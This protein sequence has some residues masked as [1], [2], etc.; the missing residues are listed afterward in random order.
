MQDVWLAPAI[1]LPAPRIAESLAPLGGLVWLDG[2]L[3]YGREGRFSFLGAEPTEVVQA[4]ADEPNPLGLLTRLSVPAAPATQGTSP[5]SPA[6]VPLWVGHLA[7]DAHPYGEAKRRHARTLTVPVVR[8]GRYEALYV[9]DHLTGLSYIAGDSPQACDRLAR[10]ISRP[11]GLA[12][13]FKAGPIL[14]PSMERHMASVEQALEHIRE[15]EVYEINLAHCF[16]AAFEGD[17][18]ALFLRMRELSPVPLGYFCQADGHALLGRSMERFLR[19]R[20]DGQ[21]VWSAPIKGTVA[22]ERDDA[23]H[24]SRALASDP[25]EQAEHAMVVDLVRSDLSR[26]ARVGSVQIEELMSV[27]PFAGLSHLVSTVRARLRDDVSLETLVRQTFPPASVTGTPKE[28]SLQLIEEL[29]A[30]ARGVYTGAVGFVDRTGG[31]SLAVSIRTAVI[32]GGSARYFAG[33]GIVL[34]S[35]PRR[36]AQETELKAQVFV[37]AL[38]R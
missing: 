7:Y 5:L 15:G 38:T 6:D 37:R 9:H 12:P 35:D 14:R 22:S 17:P 29:E 16:A 33:G 31:L 23:D 8:F 36:E 27:L 34:A 4:F 28:R 18:L 21:A 11:T 10:R 32:E 26:V 19:Y 24:Q 20:P 3:E 13:A 2:G 1:T 30:S 25:K